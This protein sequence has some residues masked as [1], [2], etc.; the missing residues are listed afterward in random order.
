MREE[1][2]MSL[3]L[4]IFSLTKNCKEESAGIHRSLISRE[5]VFQDKAQKYEPV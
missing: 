2:S 1:E 5:E 3:L 4:C